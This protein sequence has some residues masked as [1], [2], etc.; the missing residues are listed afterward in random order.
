MVGH[1]CYSVRGSIGNAIFYVKRILT[2]VIP[3]N[4]PAATVI[5]AWFQQLARR[6]PGE[7]IIKFPPFIKGD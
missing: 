1:K 2:R 7:S 5:P 4:P 6:M 3:A